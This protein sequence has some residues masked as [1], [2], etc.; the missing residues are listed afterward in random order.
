MP[1]DDGLT[2]ADTALVGLREV[3]EVD[4]MDRRHFLVVTGGALTAF[5][6]DWLF[7]PARITAA[8]AGRRIDH[9]VVDDLERL[10]DASR[11]LD[12]ALGG[13]SLLRTSREHL[14]LV[15]EILSNASYPED[16][17][18]RLYAVAAEFARIAGT[19][20]WD[21]SPGTCLPPAN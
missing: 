17:G 3:V 20:A 14:R 8:V 19:L 11:K 16:V 7:D 6:H 13:A 2:H 18:N 21:C 5:A 9:A 1:A 12:D 15:V 10:A 4:G